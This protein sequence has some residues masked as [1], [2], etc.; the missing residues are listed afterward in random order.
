MLRWLMAAAVFCLLVLFAVSGLGRAIDH[1]VQNRVL[2]VQN[3]QTWDC[4]RIAYPDG[5]T[6]HTNCHVV[7]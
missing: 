1:E 4:E 7:P 2:I 5:R 3:G 6:A